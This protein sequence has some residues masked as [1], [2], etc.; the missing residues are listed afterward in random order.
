MTAVNTMIAGPPLDAAAGEA[1]AKAA[2]WKP[3]AR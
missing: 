3:G 1:K 2:G